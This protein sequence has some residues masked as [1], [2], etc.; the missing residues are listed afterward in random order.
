MVGTRSEQINKERQSKPPVSTCRLPTQV[1]MSKS[2]QKSMIFRLLFVPFLF[3]ATLST[4]YHIS[5]LRRTSLSRHHSAS[6]D[7]NNDNKSKVV[8]CE[9]EGSCRVIRGA[10]KAELNEQRTAKRQQ[11]IGE[12]NY[13]E[14]LGGGKPPPSANDGGKKYGFSKPNRPNGQQ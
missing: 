3:L 4:A 6:T 1:L 12:D 9:T 5:H 2:N 13:L 11:G 10:L 14:M 7:G 8:T